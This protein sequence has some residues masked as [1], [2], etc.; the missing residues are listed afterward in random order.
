MLWKKFTRT[1]K[2]ENISH[3]GKSKLIFKG[4]LLVP[5][6]IFPFGAEGL[7]SGASWGLSVLGRGYPNVFPEKIWATDTSHIGYVICISDQLKYGLNMIKW[8]SV[9]PLVLEH[10]IYHF[11]SFFLVLQNHSKKSVCCVALVC[12]KTTWQ[13][14]IKPS[15]FDVLR[16]RLQR[17]KSHFAHQ[18]HDKG[19]SCHHCRFQRQKNMRDTEMFVGSLFNGHS[20]TSKLINSCFLFQRVPG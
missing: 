8:I 3:L 13:G 7:F 20:T 18:S 16:P 1:R 17:T 2:W 4:A 12:L 5:R 6:V 14:E 19:G 11:M 9:H 15:I 10:P